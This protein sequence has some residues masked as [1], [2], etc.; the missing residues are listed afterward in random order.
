MQ[1]F[2]RSLTAIVAGLT[3][4]SG[5]LSAAGKQFS[6]PL[7]FLQT[8]SDVVQIEMN[9]NVEGH[10]GVHGVASDC[11]MH[12]GGHSDDFAGDPDGRVG[13]NAGGERD[14]DQFRFSVDRFDGCRVR[15]IDHKR[16]HWFDGVSS[17]R[18]RVTKRTSAATAT[19]A[20]SAAT[21]SRS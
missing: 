1:R 18:R 2:A 3:I 4:S 12:F 9:V 8:A 21:A 5:L 17:R 16:F 15:I 6:V 14:L 11:E 20:T 10:S 7:S 19:A 13:G